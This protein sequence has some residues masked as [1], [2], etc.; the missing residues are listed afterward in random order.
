MCPGGEV[1]NASSENGGIAVNGMS[2]SR[3]DGVNANSAL[4]VSVLPEDIEGGVLGGCRVS[5]KN[6]ASG[7]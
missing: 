7:I 6:R 5:K 4:L 1:I 2:R 3:R